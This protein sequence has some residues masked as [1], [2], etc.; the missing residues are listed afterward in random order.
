DRDGVVDGL[1]VYPQAMAANL[2]RLKGL[3]FSQ[4]VLLELTQAGMSREAAYAAVQRNA[5]AVWE[6]RQGANLLDLLKADK[7][8]AGHI[9]AAKLDALFDLAHH[10]R[11]VDTIFRRV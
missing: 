5:M 9:E 8:V 11:H 3:V 4:Q 7:E 2:D 1:L 6:G 10:T